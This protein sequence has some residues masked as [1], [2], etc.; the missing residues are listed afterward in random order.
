MSTTERI[1]QQIHR[2]S[3]RM[4]TA[5][6][7]PVPPAAKTLPDLVRVPCALCGST[8]SKFER[9][10]AGYALERCRSCGFV[11]VNP[12]PTTASIAKLYTQ[13][14][15]TDWLIQLYSRIACPAVLQQ[16]EEKLDWIERV[17][18]GRGR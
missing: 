4:N 11:F 12:Q 8:D 10:V 14:K 9:T 3:E 15:D 1:P 17:L 6:E 5:V 13:K 18:P 2:G 16:Y 7:S